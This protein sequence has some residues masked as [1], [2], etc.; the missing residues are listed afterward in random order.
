[1]YTICEAGG[2]QQNIKKEQYFLKIEV[3]ILHVM[4]FREFK[5]EKVKNIGSTGL[6]WMVAN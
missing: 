2:P 6:G 1:V 4:L 5:V 3:Y